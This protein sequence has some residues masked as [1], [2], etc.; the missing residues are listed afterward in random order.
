MANETKFAKSC[1]AGHE[2][3]M[4]FFETDNLGPL[5]LALGCFKDAGT[6]AHSN[7]EHHFAIEMR[8]LVRLLTDKRSR[9]YGRVTS[10]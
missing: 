7:A 8:S 3:L 6:H 9:G 1:R 2:H 5:G 10:V 4:E